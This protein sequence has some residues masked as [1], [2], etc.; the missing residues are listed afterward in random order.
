MGVAGVILGVV[1]WKKGGCCGTDTKEEIPNPNYYIFKKQEQKKDGLDVYEPPYSIS[2][3]TE[4]RCPLC[5]FYFPVEER[6][7]FLIQLNNY[8]ESQLIALINKYNNLIGNSNRIDL[9]DVI[10]DL[11]TVHKDIEELNI[12]KKINIISI[13]VKGLLA[14]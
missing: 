9:M 12:Q 13:H 3:S 1:V 11:E 10:N 7:S 4:I 2:N 5:K 8:G 6:K 14:K